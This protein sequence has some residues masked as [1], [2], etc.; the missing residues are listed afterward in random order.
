M[1]KIGRPVVKLDWDQ[2]EDLC[3]I[4]CTQ[5]EIAQFCK[6]TIE[7]VQA[8]CLREQG[9][10]FSE[11]YQQKK[12][13]GKIS[14]RRRQYKSAVNEGDRTMMIWLGKQMLGQAEKIEAQA[15]LLVDRP[16][17]ELT[18]EELEAKLNGVS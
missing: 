2:I 7:T 18:D 3:K 15:S 8:D 6:T 1:A 13:L 10:P 17:K 11:F 9:I 12:G 4:H 14:L 5:E 16:H